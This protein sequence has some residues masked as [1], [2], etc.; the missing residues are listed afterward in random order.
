[1]IL[2]PCFAYCS[3]PEAA[4]L[5]ALLQLAMAHAHDLPCRIDDQGATQPDLTVPNPPAA[6]LNDRSVCFCA[7]TAAAA[8]GGPHAVSLLES[9]ARDSALYKQLHSAL[10]KPGATVAPAPPPPAVEPAAAAAAV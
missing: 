9:P 10:P 1:M 4:R 7:A 2:S 5:T 8:M 6:H 3:V